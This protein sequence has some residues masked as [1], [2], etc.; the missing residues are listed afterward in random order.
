VSTLEGKGTPSM[1][2]RTLV[3]PPSGRLGPVTPDERAAV[4]A[5]SPI[6][7][8]YEKKVVRAKAEMRADA[9]G[10]IAAGTRG[11]GLDIG[12]RGGLPAGD[13]G[14][15]EQ[16]GQFRVPPA[17]GNPSYRRRPART[18]GAPPPIREPSGAPPPI[19]ERSVPQIDVAVPGHRSRPNCHH[20]YQ[21]HD[22]TAL[23]LRHASACRPAPATLC[24]ASIDQA[25]PARA[26]PCPKPPWPSSHTMPYR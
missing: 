20:R 19:R 2:Q 26:R 10:G 11:G 24:L 8:K 25:K 21:G 1:V 9:G 22:P 18:S 7:G 5:A 4:I 6:A 12:P 13:D 3:R 15:L 14:G 16:H 23:A 17:P